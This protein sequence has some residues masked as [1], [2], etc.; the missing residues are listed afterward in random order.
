MIRIFSHFEGL[1]RN[2]LADAAEK[3]VDLPEIA[4][5]MGLNT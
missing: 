5:I 2:R 1:V 3:A 4:R